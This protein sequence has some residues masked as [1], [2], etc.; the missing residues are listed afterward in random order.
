MLP[1][2][3]LSAFD[4]ASHNGGVEGYRAHLKNCGTAEAAALATELI[5]R[6]TFNSDPDKLATTAAFADLENFLHVWADKQGFE[7]KVFG[8]RDAWQISLGDG[9]TLA[10]IAHGDVQPAEAK[11]WRTS[12]FV[13]VLQEA[14]LYGR[15]AED[16]KGPLAAALVALADAKAFA[17]PLQ[18]IR[19][20]IGTSEESGLTAMKRYAALP[21]AKYNVSIDGEFPVVGSQFGFV[22]WHLRAPVG[23]AKGATLTALHA[24]EFLTQIPG[25]ADASID[26]GA[27]FADA[28]R[29]RAKKLRL[30]SEIKIDGETLNVAVEGKTAHSSVPEEGDNALSALAELLRKLPLANNGYKKIIDILA[31]DFGYD[32][33]GKKIGLAYDDPEMGHLVVAPTTVHSDGKWVDLG[34]N[35]RRPRG[36]TVEEFRANM[37][38]VAVR[39]GVEEGEVYV[40]EPHVADTTGPLVKTLL[41]IYSA[42]E[43]K[44]AAVQTERGGT[45]ARLFAGGVDFGPS[46]PGEPYSGH[47][48]NEYITLRALGAQTEMLGEAILALALTKS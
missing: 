34:V 3:F 26:H 42:H 1:L 38:A 17:L 19:I 18:G 31:D 30:K 44:K 33:Y 8:A 5:A 14:K 25:H 9:N 32:W 23:E 16:D 48:D 22:E 40:G 27:S 28:L 10:F 12:P 45:Y 46:F 35:L 24:A 37:H 36:K 39:L 6:P 7:F 11:N 4:C 15:G 21:E 20:A 29:E 47:G 13:A 43:H 2:L 41:N